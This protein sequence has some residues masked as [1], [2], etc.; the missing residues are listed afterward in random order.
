MTWNNIGPFEVFWEI[1]AYNRIIKN[2]AYTRCAYIGVFL[3]EFCWDIV[4]SSGFV[5]V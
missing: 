3:N 4:E 5:S 1:I 2:I